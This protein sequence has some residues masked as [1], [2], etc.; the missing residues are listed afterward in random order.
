M[1][2]ALSILLIVLVSFAIGWYIK[3][4]NIQ[5]S[6]DLILKDLSNASKQHKRQ[7][8]QANE[9]FNM[10]EHKEQLQNNILKLKDTQT[11]VRSML[12]EI[13]HEYL[14][15]KRFIEE[16]QKVKLDSEVRL[17]KLKA[18]TSVLNNK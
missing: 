11:Q 5:N 1:L 3:H 16:N 14:E 12:K 15:K 6:I 2:I 13:E 17:E 8:Y 7:L 10:L 9:I 18:K 4:N